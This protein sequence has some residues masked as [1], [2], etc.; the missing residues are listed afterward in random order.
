MDN[1][2]EV[3]EFL[4]SRRAKITPEQAGLPPGSGRRVPGLR[5]SEVAFLASVS[6]EYYARL[7]RGNLTGASEHI[8]DAIARAL[9]LDEA[10]RTYLF[11]LARA[12]NRTPQARPRRR[13]SQQWAPR[14]SLRQMLDAIDAPAVVRNGR[15]DLLAANA[16]GRAFYTDV[17][18]QAQPNLARFCYLDLDRSQRFHP[19]WERSADINVAMLRTE[20]GRDPHDKGLQDLVGELSTRS[21]AF[22]TRWAAR[23]VRIH[24]RG[25]KTVNHPVVGELDVDYEELELTA[26]PGLIL[27]I[28]TAE[29]ASPSHERLRLLAS[30]AATEHTAE[31]AAPAS[32]AAP[33]SPAE[34]E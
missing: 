22:R 5:R 13:G 9:R 24:G 31:P 17:Y 16:L 18:A 20:A 8:L 4:T 34:P 28:Y 11:D 26:E 2:D 1:R 7:E 12:A 3:R 15:L 19:D 25:H 32:E 30:W 21:E 29:P 14:P 33:A 23:N 6:A 27:L 10:E